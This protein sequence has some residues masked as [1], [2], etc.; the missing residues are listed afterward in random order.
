MMHRHNELRAG[1]VG[2]L[3]GLLGIAVS[4]NPGVVTT[5]RHDREINR[6]ITLELSKVVGHGGVAAEN[7]SPAVALIGRQILGS[8]IAVCGGWIAALVILL[9]MQPHSGILGVMIATWFMWI[10]ILPSWLLLFL[11]LYIFIP[12][13]SMLWRWPICTSF[14]VLA[15]VA[16]FLAVVGASD[17]HITVTDWFFLALASTVGGIA[18]LTAALTS[19]YFKQATKV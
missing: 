9:L 17:R 6:A 7:D 5:D 19:K 15:G 14:G 2:H 1:V 13:S 10:F 18:C 12:H 16:I 3:H 8:F 4:A 11:P